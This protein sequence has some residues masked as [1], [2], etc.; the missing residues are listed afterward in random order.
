MKQRPRTQPFDD[1]SEEDTVRIWSRAEAA[2]WRAG[3]P[4]FSPWRLVALQVVAGAACSAFAYLVTQRAGPVGSALYGALAVVVP[5][6]MLAR[7]MS[8]SY[9][10][11]AGA[12]GHA[13]FRFMFWELVKI[14]VSVA[15]LAA[16]PKVVPGLDWLTMLVTMIVC[17]KMN[18]VALLWQRRPKTTGPKV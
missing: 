18:L 2:A 17:M 5:G 13:V 14:G 7:G 4:S 11:L 10:G 9:I 12:V 1:A 8:R 6:A 15:M 3:H 16:A